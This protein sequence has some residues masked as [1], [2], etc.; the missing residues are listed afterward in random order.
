MIHKDRMTAQLDVEFVI[1]LIGMRFNYL[2]KIHKWLP[3]F[4]AMP[5][6]YKEL[7]TKPELGFIHQET[8]FG[9]TVISVQ[10]WRSMD[11]LM[12]YAKSKESEHLPAWKRFN[13]AIG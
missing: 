8:W 4:F 10:Y 11:Q 12:A 1:F 7:Y 6:M 2:W 3:V 5:K 9:R 13:K